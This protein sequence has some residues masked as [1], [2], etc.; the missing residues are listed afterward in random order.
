VKCK[1]SLADGSRFSSFTHFMAISNTVPSVWVDSKA[2]K[3]RC[4]S[5]KKNLASFQP[6]FI[7]AIITWNDFVASWSSDLKLSQSQGLCFQSDLL[8][9]VVK[10]PGPEA[11]GQGPGPVGFSTL[12][13]GGR[14][15]VVSNLGPQG[16]QAGGR[17]FI[18]RSSRT[19]GRRPHILDLVTW[20]RPSKVFLFK[21]FYYWEIPKI[22]LLWIGITI[23]CS[24]LS[25]GNQ[26]FRNG[27]APLLA[28][29]LQFN[30]FHFC[31]FLTLIAWELQVEVL[32]F[33][34]DFLS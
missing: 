9:P 2:C 33:K 22:S 11:A 10:G 26:N 8:D 32:N 7:T 3:W 16:P 13:L 1:V 27:L 6:F 17:S 12:A 34:N 4:C 24:L 14:R 19:G 29:N 28:K 21:H 15:P 25:Q 18:C 23:F 30:V 31:S 20:P 5:K